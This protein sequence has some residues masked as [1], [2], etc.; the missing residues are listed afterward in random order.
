MSGA[1]VSTIIPVYNRPGLLLQAVGSVLE[2]A[3]RSI[4]IIVV[5][6]G[7][8]DD[9]PE[10]VDRLAA[11]HPGII[12]IVHKANGGVGLAREAGRQFARG[13]FIQYLDSDDL[14]LPRKFELQVQALL[15]HPE[16]GAAYGVTRLVDPNGRILKEP[17]KWTGRTFR[18]LLPA[19]LVD[20]WWNTQTP[21]WRRAVCDRIGPWPPMRMAED[22]AYEARAAGLGLTLAS[23][24]DTVAATRCHGG[25]RLTSGKLTRSK[26]ADMAKLIT[27]LHRAAEQVGV[28]LDCPEM[29]H[30]SRWAFAHARRCGAMGLLGQAEELHRVGM[31]ASATPDRRMALVGRCAWLLGW[32]LTGLLFGLRDRL[33]HGRPG[34]DTLKQSWMDEG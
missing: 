21:L 32:R 10:V 2:Q 33:G 26:A 29:R 15:D 8:T 13:E 6:D 5:D 14:I 31:A 7:S 23:V 34:A 28:P 4:E 30:F 9:T 25:D 19:L 27:E 17:Y 11:E 16:C 22:W 20:R 1:L 3:Y 18:H 24:P 12:R